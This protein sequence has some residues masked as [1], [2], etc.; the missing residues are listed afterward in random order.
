MLLFEK[1]TIEKLE[2][3]K[4]EIMRNWG[5]VNGKAVWQRS[6]RQ[7]TTMAAAGTLPMSMYEIEKTENINQ[8]KV[9]FK[10]FSRCDTMASGCFGKKGM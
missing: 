10:P 7:Q 5:T 8:L 3:L 1:E 9:V 4:L 6:N 2:H